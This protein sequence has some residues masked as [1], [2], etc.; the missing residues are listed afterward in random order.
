MQ[1][2]E[3]L[4]NSMLTSMKLSKIPKFYFPEGS[5]NKD[6]MEYEN[7][8]I[9]EVFGKKDEPKVLNAPEDNSTKSDNFKN[10]K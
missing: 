6:T 5:V 1:L 10:V 8:Y 3:S 4:T 7:N 9:N 2:T